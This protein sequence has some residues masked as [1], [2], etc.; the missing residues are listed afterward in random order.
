MGW[1]WGTADS[2]YALE[3]GLRDAEGACG[4]GGRGLKLSEH[5]EGGVQLIYRRKATGG[6]SGLLITGHDRTLK[7]LIRDSVT[8]GYQA[9]GLW[10]SHLSS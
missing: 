1:G 3:V 2:K 9:A 4:H 6:A 7:R 10:R 8:D 5:L